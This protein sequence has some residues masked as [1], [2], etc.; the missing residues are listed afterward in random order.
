MLFYAQ[1]LLITRVNKMKLIAITGSIGCGKTTVAG[2]IRRQ[3]Y[4][5]FDVDSWVRRLYFNKDFIK[6]IGD[7][8]PGTVDGWVVDK[9][10]L[11]NIVFNDRQQLKILESMT[12]PFLCRYLKRVVNKN[13]RCQNL[14]FLDIA[15]LF[16]MGW[17][18]YCD[19]VIVA[20]VPYEVQKRRVMERDNV[21]GDDF[22]KINNVQMSNRDKKLLADL[23]INTDKPKNLLKLEVL[24]ML[25][26][27]EKEL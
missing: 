27:L 16:E 26:G 2:M 12:H 13:S 1:A 22:D 7:T 23:V 24:A 10:K 15:L 25:D 20:D 11:R 18:K 4:V 6:S 21:G 9:R 14:F 8:F 3:G 5:V 17:Q 19:R